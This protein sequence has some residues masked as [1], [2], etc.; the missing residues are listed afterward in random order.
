MYANT[1]RRRVA[2]LLSYVFNWYVLC[3]IIVLI[4]GTHPLWIETSVA[5][6]EEPTIE[7]VPEIASITEVKE[8]PKLSCEQVVAGLIQEYGRLTELLAETN[9][10]GKRYDITQQQNK[11]ME[12][13]GSYRCAR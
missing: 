6:A 7:E 1:N 10:S 2:I 4:I 5:V 3:G 8:L 11:I 12:T 9:T 13:I